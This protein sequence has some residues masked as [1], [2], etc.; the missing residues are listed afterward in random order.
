MRR[1]WEY[2]RLA[3]KAGGKEFNYA[4]HFCGKSFITGKVLALSD[5]VRKTD[6]ASATTAGVRADFWTNGATERVVIQGRI[7][8]FTYFWALAEKSTSK[9]TVLQLQFLPL[10]EIGI[11]SRDLGYIRF[12][13]SKIN[14]VILSLFLNFTM[15]P[16][17]TAVCQGTIVN[18][19]EKDKIALFIYETKYLMYPRS[20]DL[21]PISFKN[22]FTERS[23]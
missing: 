21:I 1:L 16:W 20:R 12:F 11:R 6:S 9:F 14:G 3:E 18:F 23:W 7:S 22:A 4:E 15:V 10:K 8:V 5:H 17:K 13:V 2:Q 19:R